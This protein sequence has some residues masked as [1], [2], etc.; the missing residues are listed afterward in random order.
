MFFN[1]E[2]NI[3]VKYANNRDQERKHANNTEQ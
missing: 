1:T 2:K 3:D